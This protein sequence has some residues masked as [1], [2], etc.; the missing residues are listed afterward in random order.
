MAGRVVLVE[1]DGEL[2]ANIV[3][4]LRARGIGVDAFANPTEVVAA[5]ERGAE[6]SRALIGLDLDGLDGAKLAQTALAHIPELDVIFLT[7]GVDA[8][9]LCRAH[10]LGA[11]LW[12]PIGI[13]LLCERLATPPSRS[14]M[15]R[16][17]REPR[18]RRTGEG[19]T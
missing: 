18:A 11:V 4:S 16:R 14:G 13:G 7:G 17:V 3:K 15:V 5:L 2:R 10:A 19:S 12:K 8:E 1:R 9:V 6:W